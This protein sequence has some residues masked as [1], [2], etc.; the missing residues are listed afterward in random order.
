MSSEPQHDASKGLLQFDAE[1]KCFQIGDVQIG[2]QPGAR[3]TVMIGSMF[4]HSHKVIQDEERGEFDVDEATKRIRLQEDY[5][6]RTGNPGMLDVVGATPTAIQRH[7][8]FAAA[9]T[10]MPLLIDG[11]TTEVRLAG[12]EYVAKAGIADRVVYNSVQPEISDEELSAISKAGVRSAI[13]LTYYLLDFTAKGRV[14]A[15]RN[16]LPRCLEA[17]VDQPIVDTC[18]M[19]LATL[20]Q[21][22]S[23]IFDVK[24]EFGLP[25]GGGVHNAVAV[26]RGLKTK[27]GEQAVKPCVASA[28]ASAAAIGADF[29]LYGPIEDA[30]FIFPA[31]HGAWRQNPSRPPEIPCRLTGLSLQGLPSRRSSRWHTRMRRQSRDTPSPSQPAAR[32][33]VPSLAD[34]EFGTPYQSTMPW[35]FV[36]PLA[37]LCGH[38]RGR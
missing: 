7:L 32:H 30:P 8:E 29:V 20:G 16:L 37:S 14:Q 38:H 9:T 35:Q 3:P 33:G 10:S 25:A 1:Q 17:G 24:N 6:E 13:L 28:C 4:Y 2:G 36:S 5:S 34:G 23:A 26:W 22:C 11:T 31:G 19:D 12:L 15:V 27:M 18:V 21:A